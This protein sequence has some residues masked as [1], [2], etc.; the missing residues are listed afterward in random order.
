MWRRARGDQS[1]HSCG[2]LPADDRVRELLALLEWARRRSR[3]LRSRRL[4][5]RTTRDADRSGE[6]SGARHRWLPGISA[7]TVRILRAN[8]RVI[9]RTSWPG[10]SGIDCARAGAGRCTA[11]GA[12][13]AAPTQASLWA[14][15]RLGR[16]IDVLVNN[17]TVVTPRDHRRRPDQ[18]RTVWGT[19]SPSI[20]ARWRT[21]S[22][23][24][25]RFRSPAAAPSSTSRA[26]RHFA[27]TIL[28]HR[29][30][31]AWSPTRER[32]PRL[33]RRRHPGI[34]RRAG[35][36]AYRRQC[37]RA[38]RRAMMTRDIHWARWLRR[39]VANVIVFLASGLARRDRRND[40]HQRRVVFPL[41]RSPPRRNCFAWPG[42]QFD[43]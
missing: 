6:Q 9:L 13:L 42:E 33:W 4:T 41:S 36:R 2:G 28:M 27:A 24:N 22:R 26:A 34:R 5:N 30:R 21:V 18:W 20:S 8:A 35:L 25:R 40:R 3:R 14:G 10:R 23:R 29:R 11:V 12:D 38:A 16:H 37:D 32:R 43:I 1:D 7:C 17:A 39:G 31:R 15:G 19:R